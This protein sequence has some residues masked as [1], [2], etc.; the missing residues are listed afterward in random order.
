MARSIGEEAVHDEGEGPDESGRAKVRGQGGEHLR[1][2]IDRAAPPDEHRE[3]AIDGPATLCQRVARG[4]V[5]K[6]VEALRAA[7][8]RARRR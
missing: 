8:G 5:G 2:G 6:V 1:P 4:S 3:V 7:R